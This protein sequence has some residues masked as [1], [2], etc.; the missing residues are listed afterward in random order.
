MRMHRLRELFHHCGLLLASPELLTS[1]AMGSTLAGGKQ[2]CIAAL[3][4]LLMSRIFYQCNLNGKD[5]PLEVAAY[6]AG[7][8]G[9]S[10]G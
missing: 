10:S 5:T 2:P 3:E 8:G 6:I 4:I 7:T 9:R 1:M